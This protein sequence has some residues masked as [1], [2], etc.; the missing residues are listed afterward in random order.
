MTTL[1]VTFRNCSPAPKNLKHVVENKYLKKIL[2][3][4]QAQMAKNF[5]LINEESSLL[6]RTKLVSFFAKVNF[7]APHFPSL[8]V[9]R[10]PAAIDELVC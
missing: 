5:D 7:P 10:L 3:Q 1:I 2:T 9:S 8:T 4:I 6:K